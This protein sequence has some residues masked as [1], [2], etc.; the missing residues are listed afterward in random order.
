MLKRSFIILL[1]QLLMMGSL[2]SQT[3]DQDSLLHI[4]EKLQ[5]QSKDDDVPAEVEPVTEDILADTFLNINPIAIS[6]DSVSA[7]KRKKELAYTRN[8]DSVLKAFQDK[9]KEKKPARANLPSGSFI[10]R[11]FGGPLLKMLL[12]AMAAIFVVVIFVQL[13]KNK[14]LFKTQG[15]RLVEEEEILPEQDVLE[16]DFDQLVAQA[17]RSQDYRLAVRYQFLKILQRLRDREIIDFAADKTNSRYV[18]E[19]PLQ[20]KSDFASIIYSY[21]YVWYGEFVPS[22]AQYDILQKKYSSFNDKI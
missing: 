10:D 2:Q 8:L 9:E 19:V 22:A 16:Q 15:S 5:E 4:L 18:H 21:E 6:R 17:F 1:C 20:L 3:R 14:G 12:W 11:I 7:W 13:A